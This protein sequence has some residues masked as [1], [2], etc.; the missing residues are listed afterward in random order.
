MKRS[1]LKPSKKPMQRSAFKLADRAEAQRREQARK[2]IKK[3]TVEEGSKYL[4]ACQGEPCFLNAKCPWTDWEDPTVV[5]CHSNQSK[6]GKGKSLKAKHEF[7]V[8]GCAACHEWLDR[9]GAPYELKCAKFDDAYER[10]K[11]KRDRKMERGCTTS[12][13]KG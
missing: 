13:S 7:T 1:P 10:W 3:P 2:R 12:R 6:H 4:A 9:S 5:P 8:P 11:P